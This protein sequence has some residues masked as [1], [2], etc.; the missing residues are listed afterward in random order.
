[1]HKAQYARIQA[2]ELHQSGGAS[3]AADGTGTP[4][5]DSG[6][7]DGRRRWC[8]SAPPTSPHIPRCRPLGVRQQRGRSIKNFLPAI[9]NLPVSWAVWCETRGRTKS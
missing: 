8:V 4:W 5:H 9:G 2:L 7:L 6:A 3:H 1:M